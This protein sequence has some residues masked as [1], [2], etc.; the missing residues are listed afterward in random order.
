MTKIKTS[1]KISNKPGGSEALSLLAFSASVTMS[2]RRYL[3]LR[4]LNLVEPAA[5]LI[6]TAVM[7]RK[8]KGKNNVNKMRPATRHASD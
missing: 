4:T 7:K 1:K 3:L 6:L 2:V 8:K 5:F